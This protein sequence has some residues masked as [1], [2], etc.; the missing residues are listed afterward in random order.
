M[1]RPILALRAGMLALCAGLFAA[2][3]V[4]PSSAADLA[5]PVYKAPMYYVAPFSWSGFYVGVN[6]GYGWGSS[7]W[8]TTTTLASPDP[9]GWLAGGTFGYNYQTGN[10]VW[11]LETDIDATGIKSSTIGTGICAAPG[12]ETK[13]TWLGTAR[14]RLGY[15]WDRWLPYFTGGAA[16]GNVKM[17]PA[18]GGSESD[19]KLG[20]TVGGGAEYAFRGPWSLKLEYLYVDLGKASCSA[21]TCTGAPDVSFKSNIVRTGI[22]YRF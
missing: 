5:R 21:T 12:C 4:S 6:A 15:A 3:M 18:A 17:S 19:T 1:K 9:K 8:T 2:A 7:D 11:G 16:Y 20:W 10:W 13:N 22:N 14:G